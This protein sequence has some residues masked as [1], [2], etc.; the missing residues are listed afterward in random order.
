MP[1]LLGNGGPLSPPVVVYPFP[2]QEQLPLQ[3]AAAVTACTLTETWQF[4]RLPNAP[5]Y[6]RA[7]DAEHALV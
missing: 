6:S 4:A 3:E 2:G 5:Q 1:D 7:T